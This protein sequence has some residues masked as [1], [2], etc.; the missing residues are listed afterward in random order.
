[1]S[2][3]M[4]SSEYMRKEFE[5]EV[6]KQVTVA[7]EQQQIA[8]A[9]EDAIERRI[10]RAYNIAEMRTTLRKACQEGGE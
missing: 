9:C 2:R 3:K 10:L 5:K 7:S 4:T 1:M 6:K 8:T